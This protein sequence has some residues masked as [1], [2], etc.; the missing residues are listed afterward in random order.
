[1]QLTIAA[2]A[3]IAA[4]ASTPSISANGVAAANAIHESNRVGSI[5]RRAAKNQGRN[6]GDECTPF[7]NRINAR[8]NSPD[9]GVLSCNVGEICINDSASSIGGRCVAVSGDN[10]EAALTLGS[11]KHRELDECTKCVGLYACDG[12]VDRSKIGCGSCNG[13][14][15]CVDLASDVTVG[16]N[17][18]NG[19]LG[20]VGLQVSVGNN[21]CHD[22]KACYKVEGDDVPNNACI[23]NNMCQYHYDAIV[24]APT[25]A[26]T[27]SGAP[28][29]SISPT[30]APIKSVAP[31]V[32]CIKCTGISA[33]NN[34][35]QSKI[36]CGSCNGFGACVN[37][38][39]DVTVGTNSCNGEF[40]CVGLRVP[41]GNNSW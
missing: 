1:M 32:E 16:A 7:A 5:R 22:Y 17:S 38:A 29:S 3:I 27:G 10:N 20:C 37:L 4:S 36:G 39:S 19:N 13:F 23:G 6:S 31:T 14:G 2:S 40:S 41:V 30:S 18:C 11:S 9:V 15:A 26:P 28:T 21:S 25:G 34:V 33:C 24:S 8:R 35:D 12:I